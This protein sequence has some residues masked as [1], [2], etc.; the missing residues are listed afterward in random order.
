MEIPLRI[1]ISSGYPE[2]ETRKL[3]PNGSIA[4]FLE[5]PYTGTVLAGKIAQ[6][7]KSR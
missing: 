4:G 5:K 7:P 3:S 1:F 6:P 2:D